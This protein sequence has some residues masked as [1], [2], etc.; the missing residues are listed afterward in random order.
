MSVSKENVYDRTLLVRIEQSLFRHLKAFIR[1]HEVIS[2]CVRLRGGPLIW[3]G[4]AFCIDMRIFYEAH[5][6]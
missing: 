6:W 4:R 5:D 2:F 3:G 1:Y